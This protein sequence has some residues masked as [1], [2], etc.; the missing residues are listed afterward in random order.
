MKNN[1]PFYIIRLQAPLLL[2]RP[3]FNLNVPDNYIMLKYGDV[4]FP[5][6]NINPVNK[7]FF[8]KTINNNFGWIHND[9]GISINYNED[10]ELYF[11]DDKHYLKNYIEKKGEIEKSDLIVLA[12]NIVP[13]LL[14]NYQTDG[15]FYPSDYKLAYQ[16][17][18][19]TTK[20]AEEKNTP[21]H[22]AAMLFDWS[23]NEY[24]VAYNLLADCYHKLG[25]LNKA[26]QIHIDLVKKHFGKRYD[27]SKIGGLNS[28]I[29][30]EMIYIDYLK[31]HKK[32]S[33]EY[34]KT[35]KKTVDNIL[36]IG[37]NYYY[38]ILTI[39][40]KKWHLTSAEW[41][42]EILRSSIPREDYYYIL[43]LLSDQTTS[44]GFKE[45]INIYTV[46]E[47]YREGKQE[48]ALN[49]LSAIKPKKEFKVSLK[50]SDWLKENKIVP[51]SVIY[52]YKF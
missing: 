13:L 34:D 24:V 22:S 15:W 12:K 7:F 19:L 14:K 5:I 10:E 47:M 46:L 36:I 27:N 29:K 20:I 32:K 39:I 49:L 17:A 52:Q 41:A 11:F 50:I 33:T 21:F 1:F 48:E 40:D 31:K 23:V 2:Y 9:F 8:V 30:L 28:I 37:N 4:V 18:E 51:E 26:E 38:N 35:I 43:K 45:M 6:E 44:E 3:G 16:I 42:L 25:M